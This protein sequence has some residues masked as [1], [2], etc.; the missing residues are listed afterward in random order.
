MTQ[1]DA[2]RLSKDLGDD[3]EMPFDELEKYNAACA[4]CIGVHDGKRGARTLA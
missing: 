4:W 3:N 2:K 1:I